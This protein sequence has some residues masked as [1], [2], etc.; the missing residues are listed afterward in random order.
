MPDLPD[1]E[2]YERSV[3]GAV[4]DVFARYSDRNRFDAERFGND[5][6]AAVVEPLR[7][8]R[9]RA[10]IAMLILLSDD[11]QADSIQRLLARNGDRLAAGAESQ[12][13]RLGRT[14]ADTS[15][16][17][18]RDSEDFAGTLS[19]RVLSRSRAESVGITET[20]TATSEAEG[21]GQDI[22]ADIGIDAS[23]RWFTQ[24]DERVCDLCG[25]LHGTTQSR[26]P[27]GP[28]PAHPR[29]RCYLVYSVT[30]MPA[31]AR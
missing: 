10:I 27:V 15:R 17:W 20:T 14:M 1:R 18:L 6:A 16:D 5:I 24:L 8:I 12:A 21:I 7:E 31:G 25:P 13:S 29:C 2:T 22:L 3:T 30:R 4:L 26:W 19:D 9:Q 11:S 28:P 23:A